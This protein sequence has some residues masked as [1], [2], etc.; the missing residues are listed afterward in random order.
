MGWKAKTG[1]G[2]QPGKQNSGKKNRVKQTYPCN[3]GK[4]GTL[5][6]PVVRPR[7][8]SPG[9]CKTA[10]KGTLRI[11]RRPKKRL[12]LEKKDQKSVS[13]NPSRLRGRGRGKPSPKGRTLSNRSLV[14]NTRKERRAREKG[15]LTE[16]RPNG[17][18][19][20]GRDYRSGG[21]GGER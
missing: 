4:G 16:S 15:H 7:L 20:K 13:S 12:S 9:I 19:S 2:M 3:G 6:T 17:G 14:K 8:R 5:K 21:S 1:Q 10:G 11:R 18:K